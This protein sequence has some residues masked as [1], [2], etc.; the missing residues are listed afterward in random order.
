MSTGSQYIQ[1]G[2]ETI[3]QSAVVNLG[4]VIVKFRAEQ[5]FVDYKSGIYQSKTCNIGDQYVVN[6][7]MV[8]VGYGE[9]SGTA[10]WIVQ[11]TWGNQWGEQGYAR[12]KRGVNQ[13]GI[14]EEPLIPYAV[15]DPAKE[16]KRPYRRVLLDN[17]QTKCLDG[18]QGAIYQSKGFGDGLNKMII[19]FQG[20]AWC[21]GETY[22]ETMEDCYQRSFGEY[23]SSKDYDLFWNEP[24]VYDNDAALDP[25]W[26]NWHKF[27]LSYCDGSGHQGWVTKPINYKGKDLYFY[28][29]ENVIG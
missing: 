2:N 1:P 13:C 9:E 5:S 29:Y 14:A 28:G 20:G 21:M 23:G 12:I 10:Y 11:N 15:S 4:P 6:Q 3:L 18:T 7:Y 16:P 24:L 8:V 19:N 25:N 17:V 22:E 26:H 27:F